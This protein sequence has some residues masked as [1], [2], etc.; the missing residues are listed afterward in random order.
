ML[1]LQ[2]VLFVGCYFCVFCGWVRLCV[3][4]A[5]T[6]GGCLR[7]APDPRRR[8]FAGQARRLGELEKQKPAV[9]ITTNE[10][11]GLTHDRVVEE[12][13]PHRRRRLHPR[14]RGGADGLTMNNEIKHIVTSFFFVFLRSRKIDPTP[15]A[16]ASPPAPP[17]EAPPPQPRIDTSK[18]G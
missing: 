3:L 10:R 5:C 16:G 18:H 13:A 4:L 15:C 11:T 2:A 17:R 1:L 9:N 14:Q 6:D 8:R 12:R 7:L